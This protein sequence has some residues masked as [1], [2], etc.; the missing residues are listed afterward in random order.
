MSKKAKKILFIENEPY[1][2]ISLVWGL[3]AGIGDN[4]IIEVPKTCDEAL[5]I[6]RERNIDLIIYRKPMPCMN[7]SDML[8]LIREI[9][10]DIPMISISDLSL[11][12]DPPEFIDGYHKKSI[13]LVKL[14]QLVRE[15]LNQDNSQETSSMG[16]N[17][18]PEV[19][20]YHPS[21]KGDASGK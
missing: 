5:S 4:I 8:T 20:D 19:F 15:I 17:P 7:G 16:S 13:E 11:S 18:S 1:L 10:A 12:K 14:L 6:V 21:R 3:A 2:A 9:Q